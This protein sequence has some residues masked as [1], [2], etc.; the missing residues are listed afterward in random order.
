MQL[1]REANRELGVRLRE[2]AARERS[3]QQSLE[4]FRIKKKSQVDSEAMSCRILELLDEAA[5]SAAAEAQSK[6]DAAIQQLRHETTEQQKRLHFGDSILE[7]E[8]RQ[9]CRRL[10]GQVASAQTERDFAQAAA[11][12]THREAQATRRLKQRPPQNSCVASVQ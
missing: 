6:S 8:H 5:E 3:I 7:R 9:K 1:D 10:N 2:A 11:S 12:Q 4:T